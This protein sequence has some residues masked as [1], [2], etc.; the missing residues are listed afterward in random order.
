MVPLLWSVKPA[1]ATQ[2]V[3]VTTTSSCYPA[4]LS[5]VRQRQADSQHTASVI[6]GGLLSPFSQ[7]LAEEGDTVPECPLRLGMGIH[8]PGAQDSQDS[9]DTDHSRD[10]GCCDV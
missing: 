8:Q 7:G 6:Q 1:G 10:R 2:L 3:S 4:T 5:C 9:L